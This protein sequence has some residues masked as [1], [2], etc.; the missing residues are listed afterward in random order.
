LLR[1]SVVAVAC[2]RGCIKPITC[3]SIRTR[4]AHFCPKTVCILR[5]RQLERIVTAWPT[6]AAAALVPGTARDWTDV[7]ELS[8]ILRVRAGTIRRKL[9]TAEWACA[10][11][12]VVRSEP[13]V[14]SVWAKATGVICAGGVGSWIE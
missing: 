3:F 9:L 10:T 14:G 4:A 7:A 11:K 12:L 5:T 6:G 8:R 13:S 2:D 1:I